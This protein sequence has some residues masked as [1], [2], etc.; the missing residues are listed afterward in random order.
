MRKPAQTEPVPAKQFGVYLPAQRDFIPC[1]I[2][3]PSKKKK[4]PEKAFIITEKGNSQTT[5]F[6]KNISN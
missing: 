6:A 1:F 3:F 2:P 5:G 4:K